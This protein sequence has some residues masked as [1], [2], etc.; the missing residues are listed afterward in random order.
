MAL[1]ATFYTDLSGPYIAFVP[2]HSTYGLIGGFVAYFLNKKKDSQKAERFLVVG[3]L[4]LLVIGVAIVAHALLTAQGRI[5]TL[6]LVIKKL[7]IIVG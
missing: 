4:T 7:C 5:S 3:A 1:F 6:A 2:V